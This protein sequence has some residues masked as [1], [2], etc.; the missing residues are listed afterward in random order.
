MLTPFE[1]FNRQAENFWRIVY[2]LEKLFPIQVN[3]TTL[4]TNGCNLHFFWETRNVKQGTFLAA[5]LA[6]CLQR[7]KG[8]NW[9]TKQ[10]TV[11][12]GMLTVKVTDFIGHNTQILK[13]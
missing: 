13:I 2:L 6:T 5:A 3:R 10:L 7:D 12:A 1:N 8:D 4:N 9:K 11:K